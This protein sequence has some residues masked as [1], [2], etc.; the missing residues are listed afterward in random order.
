MVKI[1]DL[2]TDKYKF[3]PSLA[4]KFFLVNNGIKTKIFNILASKLN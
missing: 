4:T 2:L 3:Y 1:K